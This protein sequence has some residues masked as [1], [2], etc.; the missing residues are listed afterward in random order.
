MPANDHNRDIIAEINKKYFSSE[1]DEVNIMTDLG[2]CARRLI[3]VLTIEQIMALAEKYYEPNKV[4]EAKEIRS[5][6]KISRQTTF[7]YSDPFNY[8]SLR[9]IHSMM[10]DGLMI[11]LRNMF[12]STNTSNSAGSFIVRIANANN[13]KKLNEYHRSK[14]ILFGYDIGFISKKELENGKKNLNGKI[15][16]LPEYSEKTSFSIMSD[17]EKYV[18]YYDVD[19]EKA[20]RLAKKFYND[21]YLIDG[22][23]QNNISDIKEYERFYFHK[24]KWPNNKRWVIQT[25]VKKFHGVPV[26]FNYYENLCQADIDRII[27]RLEELIEIMNLYYKSC[28][29]LLP[30]RRMQIHCNVYASLP[31]MVRDICDSFTIKKPDDFDFKVTQYIEKKIPN[32]IDAMMLAK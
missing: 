28:I 17:K 13:L 2:N 10:F 26:N 1:K 22:V 3:F 24:D 21:N 25:E 18:L 32:T 23:K 16:D 9:E 19:S 7:N 12:Y 11:S 15:I 6:G 4:I 29:S 30:N 27:G 20:Q 31:K 8:D 14:Q 5:D